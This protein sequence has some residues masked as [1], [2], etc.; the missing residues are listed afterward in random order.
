[1][2][3]EKVDPPEGFLGALG[4]TPTFV[5]KSRFDIL[6]EVATEDEVRTAS[7]NFAALCAEKSVRGTIL[8]A[9]SDAVE[10]DFVSRFFA[11]SVG[12]PED[13]VTGSAHCCLA[14]YWAAKL[15]RTELSAFQASK[16][17][18]HIQVAL[19]G[20]RVQLSGQ[21]VTVT[22]GKLL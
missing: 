2:G 14:P 1:L 3:V 4:V 11:P 7:P 5:G 19:R 17:G 13:P 18:G 22:S 12:I 9:R 8:T 10:Y 21:A 15:G 20:S 16:R 6:V